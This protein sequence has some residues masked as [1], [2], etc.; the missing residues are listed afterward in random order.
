MSNDPFMDAPEP[1]SAFPKV[2]DLKG[3]LVLFTPT[4]IE[5]GI[6]SNFRDKQGNV[7]LQDRVTTDIAI[8]DG[9]LE[10]F[11]D[12]EFD[13]MWISND[14][15]V[16]QLAKALKKGDGAMVLA[17]VD[18][19]DPKK[20]AGTGNPWKLVVPTDADRQVARDYLAAKK[21]EDPFA[22]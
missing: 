2:R 7:Q 4:K 21:E 9:P 10:D 12:V 17:R 11:E 6:P 15:I 22:V 19:P 13:G 8:L 1:T 16:G 18:T 3:Y 14:T 20:A 5:R